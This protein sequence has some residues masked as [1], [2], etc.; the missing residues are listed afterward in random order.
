M[1]LTLFLVIVVIAIALGFDYTNG[2]HDAANA[3]ATSV[4]TRALT[5]RVALGMAA[6]MNFIG[7]LL[8]T[9]V[10]K[11]IGKGIIDINQFT[12]S[13][14]H[15]AQLHGLGIILAALVGAITWNLITWWFGLPS[16]SSHALIGG[17][18]GAGMASATDVLWG[19]IL[20]QVVIPMFLSPMVGF[21]LGFVLMKLVLALV[22]SLPYHRT[23]R[24]FRYAQTASAAAMAL[25]HGLQD[26]Q[27]TMG[28]IVMALMAGG[29][30]E[31]HQIVDPITGD[32]VVPTWVK[33]AAAGAITLGT[34]SGGWRIMRTLG[35]KVI[36]LDPA[37][38]FVAESVAAGVLYLTAFVFHAPI[39]TTHTVTSAIMGV[40]ATKRLSA[41]RWGVAG[42]IV[43]AWFLTLPAAG[44]VAAII[45]L[46][47]HLVIP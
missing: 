38:G 43:I 13:T 14:D 28:I 32:W 18:V 16:S 11:T 46:L 30:G 15:T 24:R 25:G 34:Y 45:Y 2:F 35:R 21:I 40:G 36:E 10:A 41:V 39:S 3:I 20:A 1:D 19:G 44:A 27:K 31:T 37:R 6:V 8:G 17:L 23:M 4:S 33:L 47:L 5:P 7:A 42:N 26:A 22:K 12:Q 9:E 29:Y